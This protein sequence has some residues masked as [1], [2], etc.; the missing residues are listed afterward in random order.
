MV[1]L[2]A[3]V[4]Y[5]VSEGPADPGALLAHGLA[6]LAQTP[7][8]KTVLV[9]TWSEVLAIAADSLERTGRASHSACG[10]GAMR[11]PIGS[12]DEVRQFVPG[13]DHGAISQLDDVFAEGRRCEIVPVHIDQH[14]ASAKLMNGCQC[15]GILCNGCVPSIPLL[16]LAEHTQLLRFQAGPAIVHQ[17]L[18]QLTALIRIIKL[19]GKASFN[20]SV[21]L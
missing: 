2:R 21:R 18:L 17:E 13:G 8:E 10:G 14:N 20:C 9:P 1:D 16:R 4:H 7:H 19:M 11:V 12:A 5:G 6:K 15:C 3:G